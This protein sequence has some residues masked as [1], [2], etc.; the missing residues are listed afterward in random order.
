MNNQYLDFDE[1]V[2]F[3]NTNSSTLYKWLQSGKVPGYKLGRQWRF[4]KDELELHLSGKT[5]NIKLHHDVLAFATFLQSRTDAPDATPDTTID[6]LAEAL[7]WD[8]FYHEAQ[9][10][11]IMPYDNAYQIRYRARDNSITSVTTIQPDLFQ[12]LDQ[13]F[14]N[15]STSLYDENSRRAYLRRSTEDSLQLIY[16]RVETVGGPCLSIRVFELDLEIP[17][18]DKITPNKE[19]LATFTQWLEKRHGIIVVSGAVG[20]G[21]T[22]TAFSL[23]HHLNRQGKIVFT[24]EDSFDT[25]SSKIHQIELYNGHPDHFDQTV[26][27]VLAADPDVVGFI[28]GAHIRL[29]QSVFEA[30]YR[31]AMTGR[32]A[33]LHINA[34]DCDAVLEKIR[35]HIPSSLNDGLIIGISSQTLVPHETKSHARRVQYQMMSF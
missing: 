18:L 20:S 4:L 21:K 3:L 7:A 33:I 5:P 19:D 23:L 13:A 9:T 24:I 31:T 25:V 28:Y 17:H 14:R 11:H 35:T 6:R 32:L 8:A 26:S 27:H 10:I 16:Q 1:A 22:T 2:T 15:L 12:Q 30:A 34:P 29:E